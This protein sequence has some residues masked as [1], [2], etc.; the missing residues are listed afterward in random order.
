[1]DPQ[2][3]RRAV[4]EVNLLAV[5]LGNPVWTLETAW[6]A[7]FGNLIPPAVARAYRTATARV[8]VSESEVHILRDVADRLSVELKVVD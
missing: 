3:P 4:A 2:H 7:V 5:Y 8:P 6:A 1:M